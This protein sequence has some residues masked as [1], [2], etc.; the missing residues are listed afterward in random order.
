MEFEISVGHRAIYKGILAC[1]EEN[2]EY[3]FYYSGWDQTQDLQHA[4]S[5]RYTALPQKPACGT[6]EIDTNKLQITEI[7]W[8]PLKIQSI[9]QTHQ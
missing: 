8:V 6:L 3:I 4:L 9:K 7:F 5:K 1:G 2:S